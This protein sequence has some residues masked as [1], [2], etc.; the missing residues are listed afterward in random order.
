M[1]YSAPAIV[2]TYLVPRLYTDGRGFQSDASIGDLTTD[3]GKD[4]CPPGADTP[5]KC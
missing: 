5:G 2:C 3:S 4:F 1:T